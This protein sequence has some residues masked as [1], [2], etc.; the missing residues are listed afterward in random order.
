MANWYD[1]VIKCIDE[2]HIPHFGIIL[3]KW[4]KKHTTII[5]KND[6]EP[7]L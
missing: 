4:K 1:S 5:S 7:F 2:S 3:N 6:S